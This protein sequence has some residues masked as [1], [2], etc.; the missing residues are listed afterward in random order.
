MIRIFAGIEVTHFKT[1]DIHALRKK[2]LLK[3]KLKF[4][5]IFKI[6]TTA[7][8]DDINPNRITIKPMPEPIRWNILK[9][10]NDFFLAIFH[11]SIFTTEPYLS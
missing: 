1:G 5:L 2:L 10:L 11:Y 3:K 9:L 6:L 4:N 8:T 7:F